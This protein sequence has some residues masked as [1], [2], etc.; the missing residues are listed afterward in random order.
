MW[1]FIKN[2]SRLFRLPNLL[3]VPGDPAAGYLLAGGIYLGSPLLLAK[4][5]AASLCFY[6]AGLVLNDLVD[7]EEDR[8]ERPSR[9]LPSGAVHHRAAQAVLL[10]LVLAGGFAII[11]TSRLVMTAGLVLLGCIAAY[12]L[13]AKKHAFWGPVCMGLCRASNL[14]L[15]AVAVYADMDAHRMAHL[16]AG[17][18]FLFIFGLTRAARLETSREKVRAACWMPPAVI[19][20][21]PI[22]GLHPPASAPWEI[23]IPYWAGMA[24]A[25]V[26]AMLVAVNFSSSPNRP[27]L[28]GEL[29]GILPLLQASWCLTAGSLLAGILLLLAWPAFRFLGRWFYA[30]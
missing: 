11:V 4:I 26:I 15:G 27:R 24:L 20:F 25:L 9:P 29:I 3:T 1:G 21:T 19:L 30:S 14:M 10:L 12:N 23:L 8:R 2:W 28:V 17:L 18:L 6:I 5:I 7:I 13:F 22:F 16:A